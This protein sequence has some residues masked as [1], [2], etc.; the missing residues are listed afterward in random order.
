MHYLQ[1]KN[2][3]KKFENFSFHIKD[4]SI[5]KGCFFGILGHSGAGKSTLLN[6]LCGFEQPDSGDILLDGKSILS[7][8]PHERGI[9]Y[10]F[11]NSLLFEGLSVY[12]N[13]AYLLKAKGLKVNEERIE[14]SLS[15]CE[16]LHVK[17]RD[18]KTLSGGE[19]QRVSLAMALM[20]RAK[21]LLLDEPFSNLDTAL[22]IKMRVFLKKIIKAH[23]ITAIM[24]T[25]DK[26]DAFLLFDNMVLLEAGNILQSGTPKSIY[27][28]PRTLSVAQYFGFENIYKIQEAN[29][30]FGLD[31]DESLEGNVLIP[32]H[33]I[34]FGDDLVQKV[35][36]KI[37]V[38]GRYKI[39]CES[40]LVFFSQF[41]VNEEFS[42]MVK[43][44]LCTIL[45]D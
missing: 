14:S 35:S 41:D 34:S 5:Q 28:N 22:K 1:I 18:V 2:L 32:Y 25:H 39:K 45:A 37:Y 21:F 15:E 44:E 42:I 43:K 19:R 40:G 13:L 20:L 4:I 30:L 3:E 17:N 8:K 23:N 27:E 10:V 9:A 26:D 29:D 31:F 6:L 16:V 11:Q 24:V 7:Q 33:A 38:E 12:E 36:E